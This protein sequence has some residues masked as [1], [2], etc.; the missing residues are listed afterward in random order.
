MSGSES[1]GASNAGKGVLMSAKDVNARA[2][3]TNS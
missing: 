3:S 1:E 2:K